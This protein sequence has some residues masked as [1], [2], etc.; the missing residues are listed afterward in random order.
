MTADQII[1]R[2]G[3]ITDRL[4]E[5]ILD[6]IESQKSV[7]A[8]RLLEEGG[9]E[10]AYL[11]AELR[12]QAGILYLLENWPSEA[13]DPSPLDSIEDDV[14][15]IEAINDSKDPLDFAVVALWH[16]ADA[17]RAFSKP[18]SASRL[19]PAEVGQSLIEAGEHAVAAMEAVCWAEHIDQ[20]QNFRLE[21]DARVAGERSRQAKQAANERHR[22]NRSMK[23][24]VWLWCDKH[25]S[26]FPSM[27]SA[28]EAIA[29]KI[30]P[31]R[32]RTARSWVSEYKRRSA[33][34]VQTAQSTKQ[35]G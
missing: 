15:L 35:T 13:D 4:T 18:Q 16:V 32:F 21:A 20:L 24:Q 2:A 11:P 29:G 1:H 6:Y 28:A 5:C 33:V 3:I 25:L 23:Q 7:L 26:T 22:E 31:I 14:S 17:V 34:C 30:V 19:G 9:W 27:D 12:N 8:E 10:L